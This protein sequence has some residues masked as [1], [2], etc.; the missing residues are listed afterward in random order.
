MSGL[1]GTKATPV[2]QTI[3]VACS[4]PTATMAPRMDEALG[5]DVLPCSLM[6]PVL[7]GTRHELLVNL[8]INKISIIPV[9]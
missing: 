1:V 7:I 5:N 6:C 8:S 2:L 3:H 4:Y 9:C